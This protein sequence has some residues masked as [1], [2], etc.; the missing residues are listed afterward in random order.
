MADYSYTSLYDGRQEVEQYTGTAQTGFEAYRALTYR[1]NAVAGLYGQLLK[2]TLPQWQNAEFDVTGWGADLAPAFYFHGDYQNSTIKVTGLD[3]TA[4]YRYG[5]TPMGQA[6]GFKHRYSDEQ[7][8]RTFSSHSPNRNVMQN[9]YTG[10]YAEPLT[11]LANM[12][13]RW[14]DAQKGRFIQGDQYNHANLMLPAGALSELMRYIGRSQNDLLRDPAQQMRYGY[15]SGNALAWVDPLGLVEVKDSGHDWNRD[16]ARLNVANVMS[17][18]ASESEIFAAQVD[19]IVAGYDL[20]SYGADGDW[21]SRS[22]RAGSAFTIESTVIAVSEETGVPAGLIMAHMH[23]ESNFDTNA[24]SYVGA[25]GLMQFMPGTAVGEGLMPYNGSGGFRDLRTNPEMNVT[26]GGAYLDYLY[27]RMDEE[28]ATD[29]DDRML[30]SAS[31]NCGPGCVNNRISREFGAYSERQGLV[32]YE[33]IADNLP[34]ETQ[35]YVDRIYGEYNDVEGNRDG[36][37]YEYYQN[38]LDC[39]D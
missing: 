17:G 1:P 7:M 27:D 24:V 36:G 33:A 25:V 4:Q 11:G 12:D 10:K 38:I 23:A 22:K 15:V 18:N 26:A 13:A 30:A 28:G 8:T 14:Y 21:G 3:A 9:L 32:D 31:Y 5:Y 20:G 19:L 34:Q 35:G 16:S 2:Q 39:A 37:L 29:L 6:Y